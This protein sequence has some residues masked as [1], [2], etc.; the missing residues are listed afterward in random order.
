MKEHFV[1][2]FNEQQL[3]EKADKLAIDKAINETGLKYIKS[4]L[5]KKKGVQYSE[6]YLVETFE[7][8]N[9]SLNP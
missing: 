3:R 8:T 5:V 9:F 7:Q 4:K 6:V 2:L 1:G